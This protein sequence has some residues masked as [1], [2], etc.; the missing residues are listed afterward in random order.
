MSDDGARL[1]AGVARG[2]P[3]LAAGGSLAF[4]HELSERLGLERRLA[5]DDLADDIVD[6]LNARSCARTSLAAVVTASVA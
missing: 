3:H 4:G 1:C 6:D 5:E 2:H